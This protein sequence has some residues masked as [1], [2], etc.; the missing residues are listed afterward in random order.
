MG[1]LL[2]FWLSTISKIVAFFIIVLGTDYKD[3][4]IGSLVSLLFFFF[5]FWEF[6]SKWYW[7]QLWQGYYLTFRI[8]YDGFSS[9]F[10]RFFLFWPYL[11]S[12]VAHL[13]SWLYF[14]FK[15]SLQ[16]WSQPFFLAGIFH[17]QKLFTPKAF[18]I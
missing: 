1:L 16:F 9:I 2:I 7:L 14:S 11:K 5:R 15:K 3:L 18:S 17:L 12:Q 4:F 13:E 8:V 6:L 10:L